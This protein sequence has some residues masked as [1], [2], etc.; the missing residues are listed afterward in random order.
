MTAAHCV[1]EGDFSAFEIGALCH[2]S[3]LPYASNGN[4]GQSSE[5]IRTIKTIM[6]PQYDHSTYDN[7]FALVKLTKRSTTTPVAMDL[8]GIADKYDSSK[9]LWAIGFGNQSPETDGVYPGRLQHVEVSFVPQL[10]C[11]WNY[12]ASINENM[13]CAADPGQDSCQGDSGGPLYDAENDVLVGVV[14]W[15]NGCALP[16][17]PGKL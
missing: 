2:L 16:G 4:C 11:K 7:D 12:G 9:K 15:G 13:L 6:H 3:T 5:T 14:S 10:V 17:Y 1:Y 8:N